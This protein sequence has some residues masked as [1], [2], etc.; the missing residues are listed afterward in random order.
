MDG[1]KISSHPK[2]HTYQLTPTFEITISSLLTEVLLI[3]DISPDVQ[4]SPGAKRRE[5]IAMTSEPVGA[6]RPE[7]CAPT[8][9]APGGLVRL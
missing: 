2:V 6:T 7:G 4:Q 1:E 8:R 9:R 5:V 3:A